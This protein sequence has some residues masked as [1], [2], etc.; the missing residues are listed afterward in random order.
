MLFLSFESVWMTDQNDKE[1]AADVLCS[2]T[3][4]LSVCFNVASSVT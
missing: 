3:G 2:A 1:L 4:L